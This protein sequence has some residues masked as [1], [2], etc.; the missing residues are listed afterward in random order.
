[1]Q[2]DVSHDLEVKVDI[3]F[4]AS[5]QDS[6]SIYKLRIKLS[7]QLCEK[8]AWINKLV[9]NTGYEL[10]QLHNVKQHSYR[11]TIIW[12]YERRI[13]NL[14]L[15]AYRVFYLFLLLSM[16][17]QSV[18]WQAETRLA[19]VRIPLGMSRIFSPHHLRGSQAR[20]ASYPIS[21]RKSVEEGAM[22]PRRWPCPTKR[23]DCGL[24]LNGPELESNFTIPCI[25][26][27]DLKTL[28]CV[29]RNTFVGRTL[30]DD[31]WDGSNS[32]IQENKNCH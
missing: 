27:T 7:A 29:W 12:N 8:W 17:A 9:T 20:P 18:Q 23:G 13:F 3:L 4:Q 2:Q 15:I 25:N 31:R 26:H 32:V 11:V 19:G 5:I 1:M 24:C 21:L 14:E 16:T 30:Q 6:S 22:L 10:R 28:P